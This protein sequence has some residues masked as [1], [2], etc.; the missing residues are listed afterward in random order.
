M[1]S[2]T[3]NIGLRW[4]TTADEFLKAAE[5]LAHGDTE[6]HR[7][8]AESTAYYAAFHCVIEAGVLLIFNEPEAQRRARTWFEHSAMKTVAAAFSNAP[9]RPSDGSNDDVM[10]RFYERL[11]AWRQQ[12]KKYDLQNPPS[13]DVQKLAG[14]FVALQ[15]RRHAADYFAP[16][17]EPQSVPR[18]TALQKVK[19]ARRF[20]KLV[21]ECESQSDGDFVQLVSEM[22]R[23]SVKS[24]RQ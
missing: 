24:P 14:I 21:S 16:V 2:A 1:Q 9:Q 22:M 5:T 15:R 20:C 12:V 4:M 7:R 11:T 3:A 8:R 19:D 6:G 23:A 10:A 13:A 17:G 18:T